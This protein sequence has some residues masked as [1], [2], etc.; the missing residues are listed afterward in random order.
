[1]LGGCWCAPFLLRS[2]VSWLVGPLP[3]SL[4]LLAKSFRPNSLKLTWSGFAVLGTCGV[5]HFGEWRPV[6]SPFWVLASQSL[7]PHQLQITNC[8]L[9]SYPK[10]RKTTHVCSNVIKD[11]LHLQKTW[12]TQCTEDGHPVR[13]LSAKHEARVQRKARMDGLVLDMSD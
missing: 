11:L 13:K 5:S 10:T 1:M 12:Y 6:T 3:A 7:H 9:Q 8:V 4:S 2:P